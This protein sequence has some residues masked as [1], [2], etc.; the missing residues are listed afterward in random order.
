M[1]D[2]VSGPA[3]VVSRL[4][5]ERRRRQQQQ[6][7]QQQEDNGIGA[8]IQANSNSKTS[9]RN[10]EQDSPLLSARLV[11]LDAEKPQSAADRRGPRRAST[12]ALDQDREQEQGREEEGEQEQE[13]A[14]SRRSVKMERQREL[15]SP[16][17]GDK[18]QNGDL[19]QLHKQQQNQNHHQQQH[20][21]QLK[22]QSALQE[23]DQ[24]HELK[25]ECEQ[26]QEVELKRSEPLKQQAAGGESKASLGDEARSVCAGCSGPIRDKFIFSVIDLLWHQDCVQCSDCSER[27][28]ERCFTY[29]GKLYCPQDYWYRF[30]PKCY[31]CREPID[32]SELVQRIKGNR[33]YHL[34]CFTCSQCK[35]RL[36]RG[37]QLH[38][39]DDKQL[40][41]KQD[42]QQLNSNSGSSSSELNNGVGLKASGNSQQLKAASRVNA[43]LNHRQANC[44]GSPSGP[45]PASNSYFTLLSPSQPA[46]AAAARAVAEANNKAKRSSLTSLDNVQDG[47]TVSEMEVDELAD[48]E[49]EPAALTTYRADTNEIEDD[50]A[51]AEEA[52]EPDEDEE[53]EE[54]DEDEGE[55]VAPSEPFN[56][57]CNDLGNNLDLEN[58]ENRLAS[59]RGNQMQQQQQA[60][61][62]KSGKSTQPTGSASVAAA[63]AGAVKRRRRRKQ[64]KR[65]AAT[66]AGARQSKSIL[67]GAT[68][69]Q[70]ASI[71]ACMQGPA[72]NG[73]GGGGAQQQQLK[74]F[75]SSSTSSTSSTASNHSSSSQRSSTSQLA[76]ARGAAAS[77]HQQRNQS[78]H[79][80]QQQQA[81]AQQLGGNGGGASQAQ[82][83]GDNNNHHNS[84]STGGHK[85]TRVRTV[86]NENQLKTL[87]D[88]YAHNPRPDA[89]MKEQLVDR[90]GLSPRVI[91]VWFQVSGRAHAWRFEGEG[92]RQF[93]EHISGREKYFWM[94]TFWRRT[95]WPRG[96]GGTRLFSNQA[97]CWVCVDSIWK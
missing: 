67:N 91:R 37:E 68:G 42:Y 58:E 62:N 17:G 19:S 73:S 34:K 27:L 25:K 47:R 12:A 84:Q 72:A 95:E 76:Q 78:R 56:V 22:D 87:R 6:Q 59:S 43:N 54:A 74:C 15:I 24:L 50:E 93:A 71:L 1:H 82:Q 45:E 69:G 20:H 26:E 31:A 30:G 18:L 16:T 55:Q 80:G 3:L 81:Q 96:S 86:L 35:R 60:A 4:V 39:I 66:V 79:L 83:H 77:V 75:S 88:C 9:I 63:P 94:A 44:K 32:K 46:G 70:S 8:P 49:R 92:A 65:E 28:H 90:T 53:L 13:Q 40:L 52:D 7:Q 33:V 2:D 10:L 5:A 41:C 11:A 38:L 97:Q 61:G 23:L 36:E 89:L 64:D 51:E 29:N 21:Q 48:G 14:G 85:P 57:F